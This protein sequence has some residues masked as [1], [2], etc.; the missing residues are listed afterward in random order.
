MCQRPQGAPPPPPKPRLLQEPGFGDERA[1]KGRQPSTTI[2]R[3][4]SRK[5]RPPARL[6]PPY[7]SGQFQGYKWTNFDIYVEKVSQSHRT[8]QGSSKDADAYLSNF[9]RA[10][11]QSHRIDQGSS[12]MALIV[13]DGTGKPESQSHRTDQGSSKPTRL[14][15]R[16]A[17]WKSRNPTVQI[18]DQG[19]SKA[20]RRER[21]ATRFEKSQSHRTDQGSSDLTATAVT[22][23]RRSSSRNPTVLIREVPTEPRSGTG[24]TSRTIRRNPTVQFRAVPSEKGIDSK[25]FDW[26][27]ESQS[28]CTDQGSSKSIMLSWPT[29]PKRSRNPTVLIRTVPSRR[30]PV[31]GASEVFV[32][33]HR[34]DQ[35]SSA[36]RMLLQKAVRNYRWSQSHRTDQGSSDRAC[37]AAATVNS[38]GRNPTVQIRAVP[39]Q[40]STQASTQTVPGRVLFR[41]RESRGR[42]SARR[43]LPGFRGT[44]VVK[45]PSRGRRPRPGWPLQSSKTRVAGKLL[46]GF[47]SGLVQGMAGTVPAMGRSALERATTVPG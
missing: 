12:A 21:R 16:S 45:E 9:W 39:R 34:A 18:T 13:E 40:A 2:A 35:G 23:G 22:R 7:R 47:S 25:T 14:K 43:A 15:A 4:V 44:S 38:A 32:Q 46:D 1:P 27:I 17:R 29:S 11:S 36:R 33:S 20:E 42:G 41:L 37:M 19:S 10:V 30:R 24:P 28:H 5:T 3:C 8:D 26:E 6:I 31:H